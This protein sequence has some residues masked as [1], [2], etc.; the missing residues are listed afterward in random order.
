MNSLKER[1]VAKTE[2][3]PSKMDT[4]TQEEEDGATSTSTHHEQPVK[5]QKKKNK[6][7]NEDLDWVLTNYDEKN[8]E[9]QSLEE[10]LKRLQTLRSYL[11][12]DAERETQFERLTALAS[13]V[14]DVPIAL[15]SLVD[16]GRQWFMS[17]RGLGDCRETPRSQAFCSHAIQTND[18]I[19]IIKDAQQDPR[20]KNNPLVTGPPYIRFYAGAPLETPE[21]YKLGTFCVIDTKPWLDGLDLDNK[22]N[23]REFAALTVQVLVSRRLRYERYQKQN[24]QLIACTA[25]DLLT[26]LSGIELSLHLLKDDNDFQQKLVTNQKDGVQETIGKC[27]DVIQEICKDVR[28]TFSTNRTSFEESFNT[29]NLDA[30]DVDHL[31]DR[32]YTVLASVKKEVPVKITVDES[33]PKRLVCDPVRIFRCA[34]N[35]LVVACQRTKTGMISLKISVDRSGGQGDDGAGNNGSSNEGKNDVDNKH[36]LLYVLCEDTAPAVDI[37]SYEYLFKPVQNGRSFLAVE[38]NEPS[39]DDTKNGSSKDKPAPGSSTGVKPELCLFSVASE[40]NVVGGEYGFRTRDETGMGCDANEQKLRSVCG[41]LFWFCLPCA[42]IKDDNMGSNKSTNEGQDMV[43]ATLSPTEASKFQKV[44]SGMMGDTEITKSSSQ[45]PLSE[46]KKRALIIEDSTVVRKMLTKILGKLGFEVSQAE[47]GMEGLEKLKSS[48]F[49]VT[50]CDFLMPIMDGLDCVKQY[51]DWE[52]YHRPWFSQRIV[53]ISAHASDADIDKGLK[54]G[55]NDYKPKPVTFKVLSELAKCDEQVQASNQ[56]DEIE[57]RQSS[58]RIAES[59]KD[60][61]PS[62]QSKP[63]PTINGRLCACLVIAGTSEN[64]HVKLMQ[65]VIK[66]TGW[67]TA[68]ASNDGEAITWLKMRTWDL[69]LVDEAFDALI[70]EFRDW[71]SK[72]RSTRQNQMIMMSENTRDQIEPN[73]KHPPGFDA[74]TAK[75]MCLNALKRL[76]EKTH[77]VLSRQGSS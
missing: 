76:L 34:M 16:L 27:S 5:R 10:E 15:V 24:S 71:E 22:Q 18:D 54:V 39:T 28:S 11:V 13:R 14:L 19:L 3:T 51:R 52:S 53:G 75:P 21:G 32:L 2:K 38:T 1:V 56:L 29:A 57:R 47:N 42:E 49:D 74:A 4:T 72:K 70:R 43:D 17:N 69:V 26:P 9:P 65:E 40:M 59:S 77:F 23:L 20:F 31:V 37:E 35:Y 67:Q 6:S 46:R 44:V 73:T 41:S 33:V 25:H 45:G 55:M 50:L 48:L 7:K 66:S 36:S 63:K 61:N 62:D 68:T 12:L 58:S 60:N 8:S 30:F 64:E